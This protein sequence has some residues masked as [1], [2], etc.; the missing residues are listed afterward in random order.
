MLAVLI[1][2]LSLIAPLTIQ[3]EE[4]SMGTVDVPEGKRYYISGL[5][6]LMDVCNLIQSYPFTDSELQKTLIYA[7]RNYHNSFS[8]DQTNLSERGW[9]LYE[10]LPEIVCDCD[11]PLKDDLHP[12]ILRMAEDFQK[13]DDVWGKAKKK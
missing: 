6:E 4:K 11:R 5:Q 9:T 12:H 1:T 10:D 7:F 3:G 8:K 2:I 13:A